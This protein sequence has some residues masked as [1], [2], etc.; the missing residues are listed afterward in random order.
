MKRILFIAP[1]SF[2]INGAE[3][4]VNIKLLKVLCAA[5]YR[6]DVISRKRK[7]TDYPLSGL[8]DVNICVNSLHVVEVDNRF[9]LSTIWL[10]ILTFFTFGVV[11]K[12]AHW[13]YS[14][15]RVCKK[16]MKENRYDVVI[17][18]SSPSELI[19]YWIRK[20]KNIKW[21][22]TWNDPFPIEKYPE[23]YGGG[24]FAKGFIG[25][26][27]LIPIMEKYPDFHIFPSER[28]RSYMLQYMNVSI[29]K[30]RIIAHVSFEK[31]AE[32]SSMKR[33]KV[34]KILHSGNVNY[35]R[36]PFLFL[37][38]LHLFLQ[39]VVDAN[40]LVDFLGVLPIGFNDKVKN[41]DL[42]SIVNVLPPVQ[43]EESIML[44]QHYDIAMLI[45]APCEEG[46]FLPTKVGDYMQTKKPIFAVSPICG[47]L[48][49]L[50]NEGYVQ[51]FANCKDAIN[52]KEELKK[53][54]SDFNFDKIKSSLQKKDYTPDYILAQYQEI[55]EI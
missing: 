17:T 7:W 24:P 6:I 28:L 46:I 4:I 33:S 42:Q 34:L 12:G 47:V 38:G 19:G 13:A 51:Y 54:Y 48:H 18:K 52:I 25:A 2:P 45:E 3:A 11:Y 30:T 20:H 40:I 39:E 15:L 29:K 31:C 22:A 37:E 49:D 8:E 10:H 44:L 23:P 36:N 21:I 16:L 43:Y 55:L 41:L 14:A 9:S 35:P 1:E 27:Q 26:R 32:Y 5:G 53:I 50:Y